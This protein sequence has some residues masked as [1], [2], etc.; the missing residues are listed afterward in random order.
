METVLKPQ[1]LDA[2]EISP[3][4]DAPPPDLAQ[5]QF[6]ILAFHL[7]QEAGSPV[8]VAADEASVEEA[9]IANHASCL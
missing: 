2:A 5:E 7:I 8:A 6:D 3:W 9:E 1:S 4:D